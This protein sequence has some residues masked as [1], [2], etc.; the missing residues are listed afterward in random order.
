MGLERRDLWRRDLDV[1]HRG[2][3]VERR[4]RCSVSPAG[5]GSGLAGFHGC[6]TRRIDLGRR[7]CWRSWMSFSSRVS[8]LSERCR[9]AVDETMPAP[10]V[11]KLGIVALRL[12]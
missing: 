3:V 2:L 7:H 1:G 4:D 8:S 12:I 6:R 9:T 11:V 10:A 5:E